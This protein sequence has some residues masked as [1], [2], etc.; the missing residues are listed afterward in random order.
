LSTAIITPNP[1]TSMEP[2]RTVMV[3]EIQARLTT[4]G[5]RGSRASAIADQFRLE[6]S[7]TRRAMTMVGNRT[8]RVDRKVAS[9]LA[10]V[11][12]A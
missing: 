8:P 7:P 11:L 6:A 5:A 3:V 10:G 1:T 4:A 12:K 9:I 2:R